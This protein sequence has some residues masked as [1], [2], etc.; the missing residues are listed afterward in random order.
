MTTSLP[1]APQSDVLATHPHNVLRRHR[2]DTVARCKIYNEADRGIK[3]CFPQNLFVLA[4]SLY[5][6]D[7]CLKYDFVILFVLLFE[8]YFLLCNSVV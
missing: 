4:N 3:C 8:L 2:P 6:D 1:I 7:L 5:T